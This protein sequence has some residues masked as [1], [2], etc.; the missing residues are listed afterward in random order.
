MIKT[1]GT[2]HQRKVC[3]LDS[4]PK[5][6]AETLALATSQSKFPRVLL[7][8]SGE[9]M[10]GKKGFGIDPDIIDRYA[11]EIGNAQNDLGV[12]I[13]V[14]VGGGNYWRG[15]THSEMDRP[16]ADYAG[17]LATAINGLALQD[18]LERHDHEV[19]VMSAVEINRVCEFY[20]RRR[21]LRHMEKGRIVI[22]VGGTGNP[23]FT[24]DTTA[25]L[26]AA[27]LNCDAIYMGKNGVSGVYDADPAT[28]PDATKFD[29]LTSLDVIKLDLGVMDATAASLANDN[30]LTM[31][32]FDGTKPGGLEE[33]LI[34]PSVGTIITS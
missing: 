28:N 12:E 16:Q 25:S 22:L 26:R 33:A 4:K 17:M 8:L 5:H 11:V 32:V 23:F 20:I 14:V 19:R 6:M 34:D 10:A 24:T 15:A 13:A 18:A 2:L 7:K 21:A 30:D 9:A 31:V 29:T 3:T 1:I 27:E